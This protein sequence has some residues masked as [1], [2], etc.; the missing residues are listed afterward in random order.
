MPEVAIDEAC[1]SARTGPGRSGGRPLVARR[2][3]ETGGGRGT[4]LD[5]FDFSVIHL[6]TISLLGS[7]TK[8]TWFL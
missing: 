2:R 6:K 4:G 7:W 5:Y 3:D 1:P 8:L